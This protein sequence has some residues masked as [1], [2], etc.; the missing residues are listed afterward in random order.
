MTACSALLNLAT[1]NANQVT[2]MAAEAYVRITRAMDRHQDDAKVQ[3][4]ACGA[5]RNLAVNDVNQVT[6]VAAEVHVRIIRAMDRHRDD[7][8]VQNTACGGVWNLAT[9]NA[10]KVT[11]VAAGAHVRIIRAMD[12]HRDDAQGAEKGLQRA[13]DPRQIRKQVAVQVALLLALAPAKRC[14]SPLLARE[15]EQLLLRQRLLLCELLL[16][17]AKAPDP[18]RKN[19]P[20]DARALVLLERARAARTRRASGLRE[21]VLRQ[22]AQPRAQAGG[23]C[24][25]AATITAVAAVDIVAVAAAAA[26]AR[27]GRPLLCRRA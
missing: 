17:A 14:H 23:A 10:N 16:P 24:R 9:N 8:Q 26:A 3:E 27:R 6:L 7:A 11:L 19:E 4:M 5:L 13:L 12:R 21:Q 25:A 22:L 1:N 18:A 20:C 2:L 15:H